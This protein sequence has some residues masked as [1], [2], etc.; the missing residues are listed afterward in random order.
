MIDQ[1]VIILSDY[2][3]GSFMLAILAVY[4]GGVLNSFTPFIYPIIPVTIAFI[5]AGE[6]FLIQA[7]MLWL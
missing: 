1:F 6:Y 4:L 3:H 7:G 2:L 5:G